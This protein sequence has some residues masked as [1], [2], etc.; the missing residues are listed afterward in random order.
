MNVIK[1]SGFGPAEVL[2]KVKVSPIIPRENEVIIKNSVAGAGYVDIMMRRGVYPHIN[3]EAF[4][5]G[6]EIAGV[7][8]TVGKS[9][10]SKYVGMRVYA[11]IPQGGYAEEILSTIENLIF[12]P[13]W[14]SD[15]ESIALGVNSLVAYFSLAL[16]KYKEIKKLLVRGANGGVGSMVLQLAVSYGIDTTAVINKQYLKPAISEIGIDKFYTDGDLSNN[17]DAI[18]DPVAGEKM[19]NFVDLLANDGD[20]ILNGASGGFPNECFGMSWL[21][22]FTKS[23]RLYFESLS[24]KDINSIREAMNEIFLLSKESRIKPIIAK[25]FN[26]DEIIKAHNFLESGGFFGKVLIII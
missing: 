4:I 9:I 2:Q 14:I 17:Y 26:L 24:S 1:V 6:I 10:D 18:I 11:I 8:K 16:I 7:I 15:E 22:R 3:P 5:P 19:D 13:E 21:T 20:Y 25:R 23:P 12:L